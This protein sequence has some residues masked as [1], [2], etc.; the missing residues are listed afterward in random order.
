MLV[1]ARRLNERILL[2]DVP[3][4][5]GV[6]SIKPSLVRLGI[7]APFH[8]SVLREEV[9][10]RPP[11]PT[12]VVTVPGADAGD[13]PEGALL[14]RLDGLGVA[15][16][17]VRRQ[18]GGA[19]TEE[20]RAALAQMEGDLQ[21]CREQLQGVFAEEAAPPPALSWEPVRGGLGI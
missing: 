17:R 21:A 9:R 15:L 4:A 5:I 16:A 10:R 1:L 8:V 14:D 7:E 18:L 11:T 3:A 6:V 12:A 13:R 20:V 2:P 19:L